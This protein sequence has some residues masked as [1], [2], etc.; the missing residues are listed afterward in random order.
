MLASVMLAFADFRSPSRKSCKVH[1][2]ATTS[3][4]MASSLTLRRLVSR[5]RT[6]EDVFARALDGDPIAFSEVYRRYSGRV[7]GYCLARLMDPEAATDA[8]QE[9]FL[10][11]LH[12]NRADIAEPRAWLFTIARNVSVDLIRKRTRSLELMGGEVTEDMAITSNATAAS[13]FS[14]QEEVRTILL[15]LR[16]MRPRYRTALI[17]REFHHESS[18]DMAVALGTTRG[19]VD[20][21]V[22]RAR[23]SFGRMYAE[24]ADLP[25][26]CRDSV[27]AIYKCKG[28]GLDPVGVARLERHLAACPEC[29]QEASRASRLDGLSSLVPFLVPAS[30]LG[31]NPLQKAAMA[32]RDFPD[33]A[34]AFGYVAPERLAPAVKVAAGLLGLSLVAAPIIGAVAPHGDQPAP[35]PDV[36]ISPDDRASAGSGGS[37]GP[38]VHHEP[39]RTR[40]QL[41][42]ELLVSHEWEQHDPSHSMPPGADAVS[43]AVQDTESSPHSSAESSGGSAAASGESCAP[44]PPAEHQSLSVDPG[45]GSLSDQEAAASDRHSDSGDLS[46][47]DR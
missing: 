25:D 42:H 16:R 39:G 33:L 6:D 22:S 31:L 5:R 45:Y 43:H 28:S 18:A 34:A 38:G 36:V 14:G 23:D 32:L 35:S 26:E 44:E 47:R 24:V 17:L 27:M 15:A 40:R 46:T 1:G 29:Q 8:M 37:A 30:R 9:V 3:G 19:A 12:T 21:L 4:A 2:A 13:E 7:Y 41:Y 10:R 11:L 20:T